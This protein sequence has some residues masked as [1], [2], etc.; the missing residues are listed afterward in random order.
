M[1]IIYAVLSL[2]SLWCGCA[3]AQTA[4]QVPDAKQLQAIE[5]DQQQRTS[6]EQKISSELLQ[7]I[8]AA[9]GKPVV[10]DVPSVRASLGEHADGRARVTIK[11][12]ISAELQNYITSQGGTEIAALPQYGMLSVSLPLASLRAVAARPEVKSIA[13]SAQPMLNQG[14]DNGGGYAAHAVRDAT[15][16]FNNATG[17][18]VRVCVISDSVDHLADAQARGWLGRVDIL[19]GQGHEDPNPGTPG[20]PGYKPGHTGEG[21]AM[22]EIIHSIAPQASLSFATSFPDPVAMIQNIVAFSRS[23]P[24]PSG[25][26]TLC[27]II[28]DDITY[29]TESPFQ[30]GGAGTVAQAVADAANKGVLYLSSAGNLGNRQSNYSGT[31]EGDF[32]PD[33]QTGVAH[34]FAPGEVLNPINSISDGTVKIA[35]QEAFLWW[36]DPLGAA[37]NDYIL[38]VKDQQGNVVGIGNTTINGNEDPVQAA[39]IP[40]T[41]K[42]LQIV[43]RPGGQ[44][45]FLHLEVTNGS[46]LGYATSGAT[47]GHNASSAANAVSVG[48]VSAQGRQTPF[49]TGEKVDNWSSDGPRQLFYGPDGR[50]LSSN[51]LTHAGGRLVEKPDILAADCV[52]TDI[53]GPPESK[54]PFCGTSAAAAEAAGIAALVL[55]RPPASPLSGKGRLKPVEV[56]QALLSTALAIEGPGW[57][58]ASGYG[59]V[60]PLP[61]LAST[62]KR[63]GYE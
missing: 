42:Y 30:D 15:F 59:I 22:L 17:Q 3:A 58:K 40:A 49:T 60:M 33:P 39:T 51:D 63:L 38:L 27:Q 11:G 37:T 20:T 9:E 54:A 16:R 10:A 31:W 34:Q 7:R 2:G 8:K 57:H 61:A 44:D 13:R 12:G 14:L 35:D 32:N 56:K 41:G 21:T 36:N 26:G 25:G 47:F 48:S 19:P 55:S 23:L 46:K 50:P 28:V 5:R 4:G 6:A 43:K 1:K 24:P 45:R 53:T 18:S 62:N 52:N 29:P